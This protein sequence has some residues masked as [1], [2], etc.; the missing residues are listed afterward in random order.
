MKRIY[1]QRLRLYIRKY[2]FYSRVVD[3]PLS[4][5]DPSRSSPQLRFNRGDVEKVLI[6]SVVRI[7]QEITDSN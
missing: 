6:R 3:N 1:K 2:I 5:A 7:E 4:S